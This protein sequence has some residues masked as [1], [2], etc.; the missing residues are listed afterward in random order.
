M[1]TYIKKIGFI[2]HRYYERELW[3]TAIHRK[4]NACKY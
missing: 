2:S 3:I 4:P 1:H